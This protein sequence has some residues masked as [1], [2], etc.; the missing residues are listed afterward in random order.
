MLASFPLFNT[1]RPPCSRRRTAAVT[2]P[3]RRRVNASRYGRAS[4]RER[5]RAGRCRSRSV[6]G[7]LGRP[8][9]AR[10]GQGPVGHRASC[11]NRQPAARSAGRAAPRSRASGPGAARPR[12][13]SRLTSRRR[14][15]HPR[16]TEMSPPLRGRPVV[17]ASAS[18]R[19]S[20]PCRPWRRRRRRPGRKARLAAQHPPH[21]SFAPRRQGWRPGSRVRPGIAAGASR[22]RQAGTHQA[23]GSPSVLLPDLGQDTRVELSADE[24]P[25]VD[26]PALVDHPRSPRFPAM[27]RSTTRGVLAGEPS[28][29]STQVDGWLPVE[30][31]VWTT[32][33]DRSLWAPS[34]GGLSRPGRNRR[35]ISER[36]RR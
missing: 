9:V 11:T 4:C 33:T 12:A 28:L 35:A 17:P 22:E 19:F 13:I 30:R 15:S 25:A 21:P 34:H 23:S 2:A 1:R 14:R 24:A 8:A 10:S 36:P 18:S 27:P 16:F 32:S 5:W 7:R 3:S 6:C 29:G 26:R 31:S 20:A